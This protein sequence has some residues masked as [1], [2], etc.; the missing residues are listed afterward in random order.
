MVDLHGSRGGSP[1][2]FDPVVLITEGTSVPPDLAEL[3]EAL[4]A[5]QHAAAA[6]ALSSKVSHELCNVSSVM[7][8]ALE[9][10]ELSVQRQAPVRDSLNRL[11]RAVD[12]LTELT[13]G[14]DR[15][16]RPATVR[17]Q[18]DLCQVLATARDLL[19]KERCLRHSV[20]LDLPEGPL[21]VWAN[22]FE[23]LQVIGNLAANACTAGDSDRVAQVTLRALPA[24]APVPRRSPDVGILPPAGLPVSVFVIADTGRGMGAD[25]LARLF[26][27]PIPRAGQEG[28]GFGL[29]IVAALVLDS[30]AA[31]WV[32]S[33]PGAGTTVT[34][35]W[36]AADVGT[37][38]TT[39]PTDGTSDG[40]V[41]AR[42]DPMFLRGINVLVVDDIL[43]LAE[44]QATMLQSAGASVSSASDPTFA[45]KMLAE[46][47][48]VW[49]V[50]VT[51]LEMPGLDGSA[52]A[53]FAT[54]LSPPVPVVLV[55]ASPETLSDDAAREFA[56][57]LS[58]PVAP[59]QLARAVRL[60]AGPPAA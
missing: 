60:A 36:P 26:R 18:R 52:L 46:Q 13:I 9:T 29:S 55:T 10:L 53:R 45:K 20:R 3:R 31:L 6:A 25:R 58:K 38:G 39:H 49:S 32:D 37:W 47:A 50:L 54:S 40:A 30:H 22:L 2:V 56:A 21:P 16:A 14:L 8:W 19:G 24:G 42:V 43:D 34:V 59:A 41:A 11:H 48:Q 12:R 33:T 7:L 44:V 27:G 4:Q 1:P 5:A 28:G 23:L 51:D 35:V 57:V 17:E 15:L